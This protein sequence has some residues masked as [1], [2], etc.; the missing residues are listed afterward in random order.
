MIVGGASSDLEEPTSGIC[1]W[2]HG[3]RDA[4]PNVS[5]LPESW[6]KV[7]HAAKELV[8]FCLV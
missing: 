7:G 4:P 2:G 8:T 5:N 3:G 1:G 6:S